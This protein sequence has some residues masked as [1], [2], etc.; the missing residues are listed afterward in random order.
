MSPAETTSIAE[1][2]ADPGDDPAGPT[3]AS[4]QT[5]VCSGK[6]IFQNRKKKRIEHNTKIK[7]EILEM[8][9]FAMS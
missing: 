6:V 1:S 9:Q 3:E 2:F 8:K 5:I 4:A 7:C